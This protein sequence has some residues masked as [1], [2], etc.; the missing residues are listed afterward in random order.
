MSSP[1]TRILSLNLGS[2]SI[3]LAEFR[4]RANGGLVLYNYRVREVLID[5]ATEGLH[6]TQIADALRQ[7]LDELQIK[8]G[9]V[10]YA[11][12][13]NSVFTRFVKLPS[14]DEEKIERIISFE[15]QQNV[16]FPIDEVV[17]DYQVVGASV[18]GQIEVVL[19][20]IKGELLEEINAAV[21]STGLRTSIVD[22]ATMALYNAFRYNYSDL[23]GCTLL[24]DI[25][26]RTTNLLF[27]EPERIFCRSVAIGGCS[28][29]SAI[30]KE[31]NEPFAAAEFRKKHDGFV[32]LGAVCTEPLNADIVHVSEIMR[33]TM[34]RLHAELM[35]SISHYRVHQHGNP[36]ERVFLSGGGASTAGLR[37]FFHEKL[38]LPIEFFNPL[39]NV[40]VAEPAALGGIVRSAYLLGEPVGLALRSANNCP[41]ELNLRP[42]SVVRRQE[43]EKRRPFLVLAAAC[44]IIGL[45]AW[46][47]YYTRAAQV[48]RR[49]TEQMQEK[50]NTMREAEAK[51]DNL[52]KQIAA[53][54]AV[55]TPLI[56]AVNDR[57]FWVELL[58]ELNARLP[59]EDIWITE[60]IPTSGGKAVG[61][62]DKRAAELAPSPAATTTP[63][64]RSTGKNEAAGTAIDGILIRGLYL[65][66]PKQQEMVVDY[67]R[68]LATSPFFNVDPKNQARYIKPTTPNN[69]EWAFP[70]EL[71]FDLRK[72]L[73][74]P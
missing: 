30:A 3:E 46:G 5:P 7:M 41:M 19:F 60:L 14:I 32:N 48:T 20:A 71:R 44:F 35:R 42:A 66:N 56:L 63:V 17:W 45:V 24:V 68:N 36:P 70:Y 62:D 55:A 22:V 73:K 11:I 8:S 40:A 25:G 13:E 21:E 65:F 50:V 47:A 53:H 33:S 72:P 16:P 37:E 15:A 6:D 59:K 51:I 28:A 2:Q 10:N 18:E 49:I 9:N 26:A 64:A 69:T 4:A 39:R 12:A 54:D 1:R 29:T 38:Q 43:L 34:T 23:S 57:S 61:V 58:E 74:L 31:F 67:F 52:R 27:I